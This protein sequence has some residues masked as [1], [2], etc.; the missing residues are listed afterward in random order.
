MQVRPENAAVNPLGGLQQMMMVVPVDPEK[1][2]AED[3]SEQYRHPGHQSLPRRSLWSF[4][5]QY[6]D[7]DEN[8]HHAIA[9]G[10]Q[11]PLVH[12]QSPPDII[13]AQPYLTVIT[14]RR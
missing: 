13:A 8:G 12:R 2:E 5:F 6:H 9:E 10:F 7:R 4:Q 1:H 11:P 14:H 3:V